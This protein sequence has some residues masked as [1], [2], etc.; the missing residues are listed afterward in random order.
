MAVAADALRH[1]LVGRPA[2]EPMD[3]KTGAEAGR[4][5]VLDSMGKPPNERS[6]AG[7]MDC[8]YCHS[9]IGL[10]GLGKDSGLLGCQFV[11][12]DPAMDCHWE[13]CMT[14]LEG[15]AL[16]SGPDIYSEVFILKIW[17]P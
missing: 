14:W 15:E 7:C 1:V 8:Y 9:A 5:F 11:Q 16:C 2:V 4:G 3:D 10:S 6:S 12:A 17:V 13:Y